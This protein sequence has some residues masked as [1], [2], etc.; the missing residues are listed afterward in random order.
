M[1]G[2]YKKWVPCTQFRTH[3]LTKLE[4][5]PQNTC[6]LTRKLKQSSPHLNY[7]EIKN[8]LLF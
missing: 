6:Y 4:Q 7:T 1:Q 2:N 3:T 8:A 5:P